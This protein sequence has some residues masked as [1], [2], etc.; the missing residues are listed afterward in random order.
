MVSN[1]WKIILY[2]NKNIHRTIKLKPIG[3]NKKILF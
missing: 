3:V 2:Y 1:I